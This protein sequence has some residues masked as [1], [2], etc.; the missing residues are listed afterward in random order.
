MKLRGLWVSVVL[1]ISIMKRRLAFIGV[2]VGLL[3]CLLVASNG[4]SAKPNELEQILIL[5]Y[6]LIEQK[7]TR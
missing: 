1:I 7:K 3:V 6:H 2:F 4:Q 5:E